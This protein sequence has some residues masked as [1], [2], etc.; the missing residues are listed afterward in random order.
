MRRVEAVSADDR[1]GRMRPVNYGP[2]VHERLRFRRASAGASVMRE[3]IEWM[4][5]PAERKGL[6][7]YYARN[8]FEAMFAPYDNEMVS[9]FSDW[10]GAAT[11]EDVLMIGTILRE[12]QPDF[13]FAQVPFVIALLDRAQQFD[14]ELRRTV[15]T[16][17]YCSAISGMRH[18]TPVEPFPED[19]SMQERAAELIQSLDLFSPAY[20]LYDD[21]RCDAEMS[22]KRAG[23]EMDDSE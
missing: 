18:G 13:V 3:V 22:I 4:R 14:P 17:L 15:S 11:P 12:A 2:W 7:T 16:E 5:K 23:F 9:F 6:F 1:D 20:Q 21:I 10:L 19:V 8:L